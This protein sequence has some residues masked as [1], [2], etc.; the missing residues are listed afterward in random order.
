[1]QLCIERQE[2]IDKQ[3][4]KFLV[5]IKYTKAS[6]T[7]KHIQK[8]EFD[9]SNFVIETYIRDRAIKEEQRE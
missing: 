1:M 4:R 3:I 6:T 9:F 2:L 8:T 7:S 5:P